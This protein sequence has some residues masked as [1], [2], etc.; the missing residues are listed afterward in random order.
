MLQKMNAFLGKWMPILT[1][2]SVVIGVL[3][4]GVLHHAAYLVPWIFAIMTF[5]GSLT[6]NFQSVKYTITHP[7]SLLLTLAIL[8]IVTPLW[9]FLI[10]HLFFQGDAYTITGLTLAVVIPTGITSVI[11][12]SLY[13]GNIALTLAIILLDTF[14][15]PFLVPL[16]MSLFVGEAVELEVWGMM[17]GLLGMIVCP[18]LP[19]CLLINFQRKKQKHGIRHFLPFP[20]LA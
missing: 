1:P 3:L 7:L 18:R 12:V 5:V 6:S 16:S 19:V 10:G 14:L 11:W 8:H 15:S 9:A 17:K 2:V 20:K 4:A 13:K